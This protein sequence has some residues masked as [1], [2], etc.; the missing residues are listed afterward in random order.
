VSEALRLCPEHGGAGE[1][2][3]KLRQAVVERASWFENETEADLDVLVAAYLAFDQ[4]GSEQTPGGGGL[5]R[6][7]GN[8][9]SLSELLL[10]E[11]PESRRSESDSKS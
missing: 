7:P 1:L 8:A 3:E 10:A 6:D 2:G 9:T 4:G 5:S 11:F